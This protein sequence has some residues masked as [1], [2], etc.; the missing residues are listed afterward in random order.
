[1]T[2]DECLALYREIINENKEYLEIFIDAC[3]EQNLAEKTI[4]N[5]L[6]TI[7][8]YLNDYL[9]YERLI[10]MKEGCYKLNDYLGDWYI[11][12]VFGARGT[13]I[14]HNCTALKRFYKI[15]L[16][17]NYINSRDYDYFVKTIKENKKEW[18]KRKDAYD[19]EYDAYWLI[20]K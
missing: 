2:N 4:K 10:K 1:M 3:K 18:I 14:N 5:Y 19:N 15:M 7:K 17:N 8:F 6:A 9:A 12:T 13:S 11:R 16:D 20:P